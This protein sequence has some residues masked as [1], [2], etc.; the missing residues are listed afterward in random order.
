MTQTERELLEFL[1]ER[2][3]DRSERGGFGGD[4]NRIRLLLDRMERELSYPDTSEKISKKP[5]HW[6][7]MK[8]NP[9]YWT[10]EKRK[11]ESG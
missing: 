7:E 4:A 5:S 1:A 3:L 6:D 9:Y 2:E 11:K 10:K 8:A